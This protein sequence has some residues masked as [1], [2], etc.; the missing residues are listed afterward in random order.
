[1]ATKTP[2]IHHILLTDSAL[3][4]ALEGKSSYVGIFNQI[5][6]PKGKD[7]IFASFFVVGRLL[8][9]PTG[10][11]SFEMRMIDPDKKAFLK[12]ELNGEVAN[13]DIEFITKVP[14]VEFKKFGKYY[15]RIFYQGKAL[16]DDNKNFFEVKEAP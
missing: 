13:G 1:M 11:Q 6:I 16:K 8:N 10:N 14:I 3:K 9:V 12:A 15:V 2:Q 5:N 7:S 4:D